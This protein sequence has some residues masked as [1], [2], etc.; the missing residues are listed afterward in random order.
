MID[1]GR[2]TVYQSLKEMIDEK[3]NLNVIDFNELVDST[4]RNIC[5]SQLLD[6]I[7]EVVTEN[8]N[9]SETKDWREALK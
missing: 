1:F 2:F 8:T 6:T 9:E 5:D 7:H 3:E 4:T